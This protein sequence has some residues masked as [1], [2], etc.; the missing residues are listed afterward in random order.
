MRIDVPGEVERLLHTTVPLP[1]WWIDI[2]AAL[3][4]TAIALHCAEELVSRHGGTV[5]RAS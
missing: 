1:T 3:N 4:A 5:W 2:R